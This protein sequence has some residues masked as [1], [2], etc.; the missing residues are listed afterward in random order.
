MGNRIL[1][2]NA[3]GGGVMW[4]CSKPP[5]P[6]ESAN[7]GKEAEGKAAATSVTQQVLYPAG[8]YILIAALYQRLSLTDGEDP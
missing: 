5:Q 7:V 6:T 1:Q 2:I 4:T 8:V 3:L